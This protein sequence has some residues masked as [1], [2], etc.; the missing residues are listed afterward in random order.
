MAT[1]TFQRFSVTVS[2]GARDGK[3][4]GVWDRDERK[5]VSF[6]RTEAQARAN[7]KRRNA[8]GHFTS[9]GKR[10][11]EGVRVS[12]E[13]GWTDHAFTVMGAYAKGRDHTSKSREAQ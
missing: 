8:G 13:C 5:V 9:V 3:R 6:H 4:F 10:V 12:C 11:A 7:V 2:A 1:T